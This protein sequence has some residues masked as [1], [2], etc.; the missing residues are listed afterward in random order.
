[1]NIYNIQ[2]DYIIVINIIKYNILKLRDDRS[3]F[4]LHALCT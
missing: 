4:Y 1:M 2:Q 3:F